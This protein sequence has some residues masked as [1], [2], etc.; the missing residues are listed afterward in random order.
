MP[1]CGRL[2]S[3]IVLNCVKLLH[4]K[5]HPISATCRSCGA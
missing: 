3:Q 1:R 2:Y 5:C 4:A